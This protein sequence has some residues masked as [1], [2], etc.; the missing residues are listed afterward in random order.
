MIIVD[1]NGRER[2]VS[3][4]GQVAG[5]SLREVQL[6]RLDFD[7]LMGASD[8]ELRHWVERLAMRFPPMQESPSF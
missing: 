8:L 6:T 4:Q 2:T 1:V 3:V 5:I 7:A